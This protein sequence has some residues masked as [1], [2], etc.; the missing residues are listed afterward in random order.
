MAFLGADYGDT[1]LQNNSTQI[2][3]DKKDIGYICTI[4][5]LEEIPNCEDAILEKVQYGSKLSTDSDS[6]GNFVHK[7]GAKFALPFF[8]VLSEPPGTMWKHDYL[9]FKDIFGN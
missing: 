5:K 8:D 3:A 4:D 9:P 2:V 7:N 6:L 1:S